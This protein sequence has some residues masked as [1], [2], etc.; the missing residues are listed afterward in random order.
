MPSRNLPA[1]HLLVAF[2]AAARHLSFKLAANEIGITPSAISQ[3][4]RKLED[5]LELRLFERLNRGIELT[6]A[7]RRYLGD[8]QRVLSDLSEINDRFHGA[9]SRSF[10]IAM[11]VVTA[12]EM[13][14]P[15][16]PRLGK[17][18]PG[19]TVEVHT[20]T[21][22][23]TFNPQSA[24]AESFDAGIRIGSG[25]WP[26]FEH[27]SIG[28]LS[29]VP[30]CVPELAAEI[31][32]WDDLHRQTLYCISSRRTEFLEALKHPVTGR[33]PQQVAN[34]V[35][36]SEVVRAVESGRG[37][38]CGVMP[39]MANLVLDGRLVF[40][41]DGACAVPESLIFLVPEG[42]PRTRE[43]DS[44]YDWLVDCY[45][46]L[47]QLDVAARGTSAIASSSR[48]TRS[49]FPRTSPDRR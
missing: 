8:M 37:V 22:M 3:R 19:A 28:R 18:L 12:L 35:T 4:I 25:P 14:I 43:L 31:G 32:D 11:N 6:E 7:G 39:L 45:R 2:E 10:A 16:L 33:Y 29:T 42:H 34:F 48:R 1:L 9:E 21:S 38:M 23:K 24:A 49:V 30:L 26:G 47:P 20:R 41:I 13:V 15:N 17:W 27:R 36:L 44:I 46:R 5:R 40:A